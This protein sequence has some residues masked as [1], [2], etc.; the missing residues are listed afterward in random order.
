M[1]LF[2]DQGE[3]SGLMGPAHAQQ[4]VSRGLGATDLVPLLGFRLFNPPEINVLRLRAV[5]E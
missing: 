3:V 5:A 1:G 2:P 4:Y